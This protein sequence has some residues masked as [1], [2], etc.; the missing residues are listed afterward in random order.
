MTNEKNPEEQTEETSSLSSNGLDYAYHRIA[1]TF[2]VL[3]EDELTDLAQDIKKHGQQEPIKL[4]EGKI[5]D[6]R[7]RYLACK[8]AGVEP[9]FED[10]DGTE[11]AAISYVWSENFH[12]RH[13]SSSQRA[14]FVV[15]RNDIMQVVKEKAKERQ[16]EA[17]KN[18]GKGTKNESQQI[19]EAIEPK[20][21]NESASII[22]TAGSTNRQYIRDAEKIK[23]K[24]PSVHETVKRGSIKIPAAKKVICLK[25]EKQEEHK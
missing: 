20:E 19:A 13:F 17:G 12:R 6:G 21:T 22:A 9:K 10:W 25:P 1:N 7:N 3:S 23:E 15:E 16:I 4:F 14:A 18:F 24:T 5:L 8:K 2:P 11:Y